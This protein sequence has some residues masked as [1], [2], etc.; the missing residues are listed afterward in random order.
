MWLSEQEVINEP[1]FVLAELKIC[2]EGVVVT[3]YLICF[4]FPHSYICC[5]KTFDSGHKEKHADLALILR[6]R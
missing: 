5:L 4:P 6:S 1:D 2:F 3:I